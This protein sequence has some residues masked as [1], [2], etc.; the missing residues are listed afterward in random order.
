MEECIICFEE[1]T[2]FMFFPC[3]HKV[4]AECYKRLTQCPL[5]NCTFDPEIQIV[6]DV[7]PRVKSKMCSR[8]CCI[9]ASSFLVCIAYQSLTQSEL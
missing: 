6:T 9:I 7:R 4:C 8:V 5:C 3:S 2:E 1:T